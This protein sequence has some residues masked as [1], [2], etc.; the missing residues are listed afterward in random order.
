MVNGDNC[1]EA[2]AFDSRKIINNELIIMLCTLKIVI[3]KWGTEERAYF[4]LSN[5]STKPKG[6][7]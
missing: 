4:N 5:K 6:L 7:L 3:Y 2:Q 1:K